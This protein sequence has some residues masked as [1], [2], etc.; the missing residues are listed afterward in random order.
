MNTPENEL[1]RLVEWIRLYIR[2]VEE[3]HLTFIKTFEITSPLS[4]WVAGQIPQMGFIHV[5]GILSSYQFHGIGC[6]VT[7]RK[8]TIDFDYGRDHRTDGFDP[9]RIFLF[10]RDKTKDPLSTL[11]VKELETLFGVLEKNGVIQKPSMS[12]GSHLYYFNSYLVPNET[13]VPTHK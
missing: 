13:K 9:W 4:A 8:Q 11:S 10:L 7:I 5:N 1:T 12:L 2:K 6:R 3:I